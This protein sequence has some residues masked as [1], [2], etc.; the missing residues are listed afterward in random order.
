[1]LLQVQGRILALVVRP[2]AQPDS[3]VLCVWGM[4]HYCSFDRQRHCTAPTPSPYVTTSRIHPAQ[5]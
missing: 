1:V 2:V 5:Q 4:T 3:C